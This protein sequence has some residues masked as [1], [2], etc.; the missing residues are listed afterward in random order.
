MSTCRKTNKN[1]NCGGQELTTPPVVC[2]GFQ[3]CLPF[4]R[5]LVY[6]GDC[7][8][9]EGTTSVP[10]G[11]YG[12]FKLVDGCLTEAFPEDVP[13][14]TPPPCLP[15]P[16][17]C[18]GGGTEAAGLTPSADNLLFYDGAGRL[19]GRLYAE[20]G[21]G[22]QVSGAGTESSPLRISSIVEPND[23]RITSSTPDVI[24][25]DGQGSESQP[26]DIKHAGSPA[27]NGQDLAGFTVDS[28][29]HIRGYQ[30]P[31][32]SSI[33]TLQGTPGEINAPN[34]QG[35]VIIS[36]FKKFDSPQFFQ[37]GD[38]RVKVDLCGRVEAVTDNPLAVED[39][40]SKVFTG[41][42]TDFY[43]NFETGRAGRL[44][45]SYKGDLGQAASGTGLISLPANIGLLL[46][47]ASLEAYA[48]VADGR[49]VGLEAVS[50]EA[51]EIGQHLISITLPAAINVPGF[52]DV[53][54]CR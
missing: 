47:N 5:T 42:R 22:I 28:Y 48:V 53:T 8:R 25:I 23:T 35:A 21:S 2:E 11:V 7:L 51:Y 50:A 54:V 27:N 45:L 16:T 26:Y 31:A 39:R 12:R 20:Q 6:D 24:Q 36:L 30:A 34:N 18:G 43:F 14:Y 15:A 37:A 40:F 52:L 38:H 33:V 44:R 41:N 19:M 13:V 10:D 9:L 17:P 3:L 4:G 1:D 46:D 32:A 49:V 29:G